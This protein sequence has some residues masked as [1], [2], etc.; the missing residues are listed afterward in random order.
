MNNTHVSVDA[1]AYVFLIYEWKSV[2]AV[3]K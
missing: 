1:A 3:F 2:G